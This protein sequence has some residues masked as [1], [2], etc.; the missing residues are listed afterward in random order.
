MKFF[1]IVTV[2]ASVLVGVSCDSCFRFD[3][4]DAWLYFNSTVNITNTA[5]YKLE[6]MTKKDN[7]LIFYA[8]GGQRDFEALFLQN[9]HLTYFL[10]NP[11]E[12]GTG[13]S[14]GSYIE[15]PKKIHLNKRYKIEFYRN[16]GF[17]QSDGTNT[18]KS[19]IKVNDKESKKVGFCADVKINPPFYL[20]GTNDEIKTNV[21]RFE[22]DILH[23]MELESGQI[24]VKPT[25][26]QSVS[27]CQI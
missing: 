8:R 6:I 19:G 16:K 13:S 14:H 24:F 12:Y 4:V 1:I 5:H 26:R 10:F 27:K 11:T 2:A 22:G 7:G 3:G 25:F 23:F 9:G 21:P 17:K 20:G 15:S 18:F